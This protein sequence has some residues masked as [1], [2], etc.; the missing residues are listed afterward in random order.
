[1]FFIVA[2]ALAR[3]YVRVT[4]LIL[5]PIILNSSQGHT[6]SSCIQRCYLTRTSC[7]SVN[8]SVPYVFCP[9]RH[10]SAQAI[11]YL[12]TSSGSRVSTSLI[13]VSKGRRSSELQSI[14]PFFVGNSSPPKISGGTFYQVQGSSP[15]RAKN[16]KTSMDDNQNNYMNNPIGPFFVTH[17]PPP[18]MTGN[19]FYEVQGTY[20]GGARMS[21][22]D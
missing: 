21:S 1:M 3:T 20:T 17:P 14:M 5:A 16:G 10:S 4:R 2:S 11:L 13:P 22:I 12:S 6:Q 7:I 15:G 9:F 8:R 18:A 19:S